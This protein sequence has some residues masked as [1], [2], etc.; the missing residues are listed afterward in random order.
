[1][2]TRGKHQNESNRLTQVRI[3]L[4]FTVSQSFRASLTTKLLTENP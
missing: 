2:Y 4:E 1:M 3:K